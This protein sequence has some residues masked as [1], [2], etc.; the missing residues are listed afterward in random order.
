MAPGV[1]FRGKGDPHV[2]TQSEEAFLRS[3]RADRPLHLIS[4]VTC[5]SQRSLRPGEGADIGFDD[6]VTPLEESHLRRESGGASLKRMAARKGHGDLSTAGALVGRE[7]C[8]NGCWEAT[9]RSAPSALCTL[10]S[11]ILLHLLRHHSPSNINLAG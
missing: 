6:S 4:R 10:E 7:M 8:G 5:Q 2:F 9:A 1:A 11:L 3:F